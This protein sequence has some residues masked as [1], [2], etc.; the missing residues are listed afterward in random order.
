MAHFSGIGSFLSMYSLVKVSIKNWPTFLLQKTEV[1]LLL[2]NQPISHLFGGVL[3]AKC[4]DHHVATHG[5]SPFTL[6]LDGRETVRNV[7][8]WI[9]EYV[10]SIASRHLPTR[11]GRKPLPR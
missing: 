7:A 5:F 4:H 1:G 10:E 9:V 6:F 3:V 2:F 8:E 11:Q